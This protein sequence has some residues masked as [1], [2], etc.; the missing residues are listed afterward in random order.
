MHAHASMAPTRSAPMIHNTIIDQR[1]TDVT[2][3]YIM[4]YTH[5][6]HASVRGQEKFEG[7][8]YVQI[9]LSH[10]EHFYVDCCQDRLA[11]QNNYRISC[12]VK[13]LTLHALS[14]HVLNSTN[15]TTPN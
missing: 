1:P 11:L 4:V 13:L 10:E 15:S 6:L 2:R 9:H 7:Q 8:L 14:L 12:R 3:F 5:R